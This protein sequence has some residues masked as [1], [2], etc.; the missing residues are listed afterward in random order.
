MRELVIEE[1]DRELIAIATKLIRQRYTPIRHHVAA[2][3]LAS[4]G[5]IYQGLHVGWGRM[6]LC[7]EQVAL[8]NALTAGE[9][10]LISCVAVMA[11]APSGDTDVASPC[12]T[13]REVLRFY[14]PDLTVLV[15]DEKRVSKTYIADLLPAPWLPLSAGNYVP[16]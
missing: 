7:A 3:L 14:A 10:E 8:A 2:A 11:R 12:G 15:I 13:C 9:M 6:N 1:R 4:S 16:R 5:T